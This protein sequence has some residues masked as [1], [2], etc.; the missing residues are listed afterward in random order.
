MIS[1]IFNLFKK[2]KE[3]KDCI[4]SVENTI[5]LNP[6]TFKSWAERKNISEEDLRFELEVCKGF[7]VQLDPLCPRK[8]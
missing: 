6:S 2:K 4:Y 7:K 1:K 8:R 5:I 3:P